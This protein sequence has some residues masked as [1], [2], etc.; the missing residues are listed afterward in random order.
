MISPR[1]THS[2]LLLQLGNVAV[3]LLQ[4]LLQC[5]GLNMHAL[6]GANGVS[7]RQTLNTREESNQNSPKWKKIQ[8]K[9]RD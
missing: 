3:Q 6:N 7:R 8:K 9:E 5:H 2:H 1:P 4:V